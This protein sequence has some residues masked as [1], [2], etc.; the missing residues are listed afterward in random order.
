MGQTV[1]V[2]RNVR[3]GE[4]LGATDLVFSPDDGGYYLSQH[5]F[6]RKTS[7]VSKKIWFEEQ[8]ALNAFNSGKVKWEKDR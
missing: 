7:R 8:T 4:L 1:Q 2:L 5:D 6:K 3:T